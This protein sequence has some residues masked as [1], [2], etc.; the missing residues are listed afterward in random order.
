MKLIDMYKLGVQTG[1]GNDPRGQDA[2]DR[3]LRKA[4]KE[5]DKLEEKDRIFFDTDRLWNPYPDSRLQ[6]GNPET[7][8]KSVLV[9]I[10]IGTEEMV[11]ADRLREKGSRIDAVLSHH[12]GGLGII[13][14]AKLM[15]IQSDLLAK[16]GIPI[17]VA[18]DL[19]IPRAQEVDQRIYSSNHYKAADAA[20]LLGIPLFSLHTPA[21]NSVQSYLQ[22]LIDQKNP[23]TVGDIVELIESIPEYYLAKVRGLPAK[24][25]NG[26]GDKRAGKTIVDMTGGTTG[27]KDMFSYLSDRDVGTIVMMHI[28]KDYVDEAKKH[29]INIVNVGHMASDSVGMNILLDKFEEKGV[30]IL[31]TSGMIRVAPDY[32]KDFEPGKSELPASFAR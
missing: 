30:G 4:K 11:L 6:Y 5:Y 17:N 31:S 32:R 14:L 2:V 15:L 21:D 7:E 25:E 24:I 26:S 19:V 8:I 29:H 16:C 10:D 18:E 1:I 28:P 3:D 20:R 13:G 9:G 22:G 27:P 12:P 23:E